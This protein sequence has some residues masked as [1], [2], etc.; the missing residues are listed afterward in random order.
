MVTFNNCA[1]ELQAEKMWTLP[2]KLRVG[3]VW[4]DPPKMFLLEVDRMH[5]SKG[6]A[7]RLFHY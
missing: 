1:I 3:V 7:K 5:Y 6:Y 2:I 4:K